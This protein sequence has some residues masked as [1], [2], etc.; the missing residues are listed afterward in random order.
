[1]T[2]LE[3]RRPVSSGATSQPDPPPELPNVDAARQFYLYGA[4]AVYYGGSYVT[5]LCAYPSASG[6]GRREALLEEAAREL[7]RLRKLPQGWDGYRAAQIS[8][9]AIYGAGWVLDA[10]LAADS[11]KPQVF[12]TADGGVQIEWYADGDE[13]TIDIDPAGEAAVLAE[14]DGETVAEDIFDPQTPDESILQIA[15]LVKEIS[16]RIVQAKRGN[17][18]DARGK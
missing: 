1:M 15:S 9:A 12:P 6:I 4:D 10:I 8:K 11:C 3:D 7:L 17:R 14:F 18:A 5:T 16:A 13:I 2:I